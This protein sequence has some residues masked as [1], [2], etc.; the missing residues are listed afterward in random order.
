VGYVCGEGEMMEKIDLYYAI[1]DCG[2]G[3]S[4][5]FWYLSQEEAIEA[6]EEEKYGQSPDGPYVVETF[7]GSNIHLDAIDT[8]QRKAFDRLQKEGYDLLFSLDGQ[9]CL[10]NFYGRIGVFYTPIVDGKETNMYQI[11]F[12]DFIACPIHYRLSHPL[13]A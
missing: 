9:E 8:N 2:D 5:V 12:C 13:S 4:S 10:A 3:S 11:A 7:V 1:F 6:M